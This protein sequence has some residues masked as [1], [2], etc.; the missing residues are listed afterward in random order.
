MLE[1][2]IHEPLARE[3]AQ[4]LLMLSSLNKIDFDFFDLVDSFF[5][6][7]LVYWLLLFI[8]VSLLV[9]WMPLHQLLLKLSRKLKI[10]LSHEEAYIVQPGSL[11]CSLI[12]AFTDNILMEAYNDYL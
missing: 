6:S 9:L 8:L 1:R 10:S 4:P 7:L 11:L 3:I 5:F 2:L 12:C